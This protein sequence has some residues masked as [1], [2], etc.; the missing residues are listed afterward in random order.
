VKTTVE[1]ARK[2]RGTGAAAGAAWVGPGARFRLFRG[3]GVVSFAAALVLL[4]AVLEASAREQV[5]EFNT[6]NVAPKLDITW[7]VVLSGDFVGVTVQDSELVL[8]A[9]AGAFGVN[10][11]GL[12]PIGG[13]D[14]P[15]ITPADEPADWTAEFDAYGVVYKITLRQD[16]VLQSGE[17][18]TVKIPVT[19]KLL[20]EKVEE[21]PVVCEF[22]DFR[23]Q[24]TPESRSLDYTF[25]IAVMATYYPNDIT[26]FAQSESWTTES[27]SGDRK[28]EFQ[29]IQ[30]KVQAGTTL[31]LKDMRVPL[32]GQH[33]EDRQGIFRIA[34]IGRDSK[35][36]LVATQCEV[37]L[38]PP[39]A[40]DSAPE[41]A[42]PASR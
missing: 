30:S 38:R 10:R 2:G 39:W 24:G 3:R 19:V 40:S 5:V 33:P 25:A 7:Q 32:F 9:N 42:S 22:R 12:N 4:G 8:T 13:T 6:K 41:T 34:L 11:V 1:E 28:E 35:G 17:R 27:G 18:E 36:R 26:F 15:K 20:E 23:V 37:P 14:R 21:R 31:V 16:V 29:A